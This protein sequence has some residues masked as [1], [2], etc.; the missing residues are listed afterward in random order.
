MG[1]IDD[2]LQS[3]GL[4]SSVGTYA[5]PHDDEKITV[6]ISQAAGQEIALPFLVTLAPL[7]R[8][9][10][11]PFAKA[12]APASVVLILITVTPIGHPLTQAVPHVPA[13]AKNV[14][15]EIPQI[16]ACP[17]PVAQKVSQIATIAVSIMPPLIT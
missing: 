9:L 3:D 13:V 17:Y 16:L 1:L 15:D 4:E 11:E 2:G 5:T 12:A 7:C 6:L 8:P 14:D 10:G